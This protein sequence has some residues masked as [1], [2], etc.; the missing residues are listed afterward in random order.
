MALCYAKQRSVPMPQRALCYT[1]GRSYQTGHFVIPQAAVYYREHF[2][3]PSQKIGVRLR[4]CGQ[5]PRKRGNGRCPVSHL[6]GTGQGARVDFSAPGSPPPPRAPQVSGLARPPLTCPGPS[7]T[8]SPRAVNPGRVG[9]SLALHRALRTM[10]GLF[11][12]LVFWV[13]AG[14]CQRNGVG[15]F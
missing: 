3:I 7:V 13:L 2:A 8:L 1:R 11:F 15:V 14:A 4:R 6:D 12:L 9:P 5:V 10:A